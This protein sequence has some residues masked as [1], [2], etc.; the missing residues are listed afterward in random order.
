M[1]LHLTVQKEYTSK[2][3]SFAP[4]FFSS[5]VNV[6][7]YSSKESDM[8]VCGE[9]EREREKEG[10]LAQLH[11]ERGNLWSPCLWGWQV[12]IHGVRDGKNDG[13]YI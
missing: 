7:I 9:R 12:H 6:Y 1:H 8:C 10:G 11:R 4:G 5:R 3:I 2:G 13:Q